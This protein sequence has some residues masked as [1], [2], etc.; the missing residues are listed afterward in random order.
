[1]KTFNEF[2]AEAKKKCPEGKTR[3][4]DGKCVKKK[5]SR[6]STVKKIIVLGG[7]GRRYSGGG[8]HDKDHDN[9]HTYQGDR[10][11]IVSDGGYG[12]GGDGGGGGE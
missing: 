9:G 10:D 1:M 5:S 6:K 12:G 3:N 4:K 8:Y 2:L 11:N 7:L